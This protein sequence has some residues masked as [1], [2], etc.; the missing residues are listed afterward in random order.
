MDP[1]QRMD[2]KLRRS[3]R[4]HAQQIALATFSA[5]DRA[6]QVAYESR[7]LSDATRKRLA[8]RVEELRRIELRNGRDF[9]RETLFLFAL[10]EEQAKRMATKG[11]SPAA[12]Q[13]QRRVQS[14]QARTTGGRGDERRE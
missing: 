5:A 10:G 13:A 9:P 7:S 8:P 4:R 12:Q 3:E 14:Q 1:E 6:D 11:T 2:E